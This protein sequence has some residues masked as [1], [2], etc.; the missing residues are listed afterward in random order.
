MALRNK[1]RSMRRL[2]VITIALLLSTAGLSAVGT[3]TARAAAGCS[4]AYTVNSDWGSGFTVTITVTNLGAPLTS[5]TL[6]YSYS[7]NQKLVNGWNGNW[8]Q[9]GQAVTV[10]NASWNGNLGTGQSA[11][12]GAQFSYTGTNT[13]PTVFTLNGA[14]CTGQVTN[15]AS[16]VVSP[17]SQNI[18]QGG[19][20]T[21]GVSLSSAPAGNVTVST[22][23]T[24]GNT[25]LSVSGGGSLTFTPSNFATPQNVTISADASSTGAATFTVS[26]T[27][28]T[29]VTFTANETGSGG[30]GPAP[31]LH[32]SGNKLLNAAGQRVILRGVDRSG[33]EYSC[34]NGTGIFDGEMDQAAINAIKSWGSNAVRVPL[35]EACWNGESYVAAADAGTNYQN[36]IKAEVNLM[37]SSGLVVI[38]DLHWTDG[39]YTGNS[40]GNCPSGKTAEAFCQKPMPDA[41]QAI[42]FWSSVATAF[43]GNDAVIFD[44]F[45]EPF[46]SRADNNNTAEGWQCWATGSPC[47][48]IGYPVAGM[49]QMVNA[50]RSAG[51]NNVIM[52]GGEEYAND[53]TGWLANKPSDPDNNLVASWHSYN[54]NF[55]SSQSCWTSQ[56]APVIASVPL[57]AGEIGEKDCGGGYINPLTTWLDSQSASYLAWAWNADFDCSSGP[58]LVT[59]YVP[60]DPT[61]FGAAYKAHLA[62][63]GL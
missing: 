60:G 24:S 1:W 26:A 19:T 29:S 13:A 34:V 28:L 15:T 23:R 4:A 59:D 32:V 20:G 8:T 56:V 39:N 6:G 48:G 11:Q 27:G 57:I 49:Q 22:S 44:L 43:K 35:N 50:V 54:F 37:N 17:T 9:S 52:L 55:C 36:A 63:L 25:G 47:T 2:V 41:A 61:A 62:S 21:V 12:P 5:W 40:A 18:N 53:L 10:T 3:G 7:G 45:N 16:L 46:A 51:A 38:L 58:G 42:P 31:Q 33:A 14:T 30:G